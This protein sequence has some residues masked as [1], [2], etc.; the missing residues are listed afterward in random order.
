MD[1][2]IT[3]YAALGAVL[4]ALVAGFFSFI[5]LV[6]SKENKISEFRLNW[7]DGL[8]DEVAKF[9]SATTELVRLDTHQGEITVAEWL[10]LGAQPYRD[11]RESLSKIQLRLNPDHVASQIEGNDAKLMAA[12]VIARS[13][14]NKAVNGNGS[15][16]AVTEHVDLVRSAAA[17]LLKEQWER[18]KKG[19]PTYR[20]VRVVAW[21]IILLGVL[22]LAGGTTYLV[23]HAG[24]ASNNSSKPNP[25]RGSA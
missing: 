14:F 8:R 10:E 3:V 2:P 17:P 7:I 22:F 11:A 9:T 1:I 24:S 4:A 20:R 12:V 15:Y 13:H 6:S 5:G 19:E 23:V 18:V 21:L 25:L 16:D